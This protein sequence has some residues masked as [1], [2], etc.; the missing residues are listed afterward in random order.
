MENISFR[1]NCNLDVWVPSCSCE[2]QVLE[3]L[4]TTWQVRPTQEFI[5]YGWYKYKGLKRPLLSCEVC[6]NT[7]VYK[8]HSPRSLV[9]SSGGMTKGI[10]RHGHRRHCCR[11]SFPDSLMMHSYSH[12]SYRLN[13]LP[14]IKRISQWAREWQRDLTSLRQQVPICHAMKLLILA[15]F[16]T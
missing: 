14:L 8:G 9:R 3:H 10:L 11:V 5:S 1:I 6:L 16:L 12:Q 4:V 2:G 13:E 15:R 7:G